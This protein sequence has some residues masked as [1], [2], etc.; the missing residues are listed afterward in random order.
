MA[1]AVAA[2]CSCGPAA[3]MSLSSPDFKDGSVLP[4][5]HVYP[6]C[7]GQNISP[8]LSWSGVPQGTASVV[9]TMIDVSVKPNG[10]SHW[11]VVN[12]PGTATSLARGLKALP[13]PAQAVASNFGDRYYDGPCP[14][15]G[16]GTHRYEFTAWAIAPGVDVPIRPDMSANELLKM[17]AGATS[18]HATIAV[19]VSAK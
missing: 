14:P 1:M 13:A 19:K 12:L 16:T 8:E 3:A 9:L 15:R 2:M 5:A 17:L 4:A 18:D 10:W 11:I 7:G 6:R